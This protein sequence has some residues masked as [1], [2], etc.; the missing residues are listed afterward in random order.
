MQLKIG[1]YWSEL[2]LQLLFFPSGPQHLASWTPSVSWRPSWASASSSH[3]SASLRQ[4][5]SYLLLAHSPLV[6]SLQPSYLRREAK[7]CSKAN[8]QQWAAEHYWSVCVCLTTRADRPWEPQRCPSHTN[9][10]DCHPHCKPRILWNGLHHSM[11][12]QSHS[13]SEKSTQT[14]K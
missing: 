10:T 1:T 2:L 12:I 11:S 4:Y 5:P 7:S 9:R 14:Q 6:V 13:D 8:D 3:S